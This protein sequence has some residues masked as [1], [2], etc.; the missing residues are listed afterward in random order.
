M[1]PPI[2]SARSSSSPPRAGIY[3]TLKLRSRREVVDID[4]GVG[5]GQG[6]S[7]PLFD[8]GGSAEPV[9]ISLLE[10]RSV[11]RRANTCKSEGVNIHKGSV[12]HGQ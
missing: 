2:R 12:D 4:F 10:N 9:R 6:C 3:I 5:A 1:F 11:R 7:A 8:V